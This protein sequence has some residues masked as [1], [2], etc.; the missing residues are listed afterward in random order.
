MNTY[1]KMYSSNSKARKWLIEKGFTDIQL[2]PHTRWSK[3][4]HIE[5]LAFDGIAKNNSWVI[6]FQIKSNEKPSQKI[7]QKMFDLSQHYSNVMRFVWI[8]CPD[9]KPIE[10]YGL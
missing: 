2:F 10:V 5:S 3:D 9:R 7:L 1:S 4:I 8:N 6:L